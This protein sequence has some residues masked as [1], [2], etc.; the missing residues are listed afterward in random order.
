V[1][2]DVRRQLDRETR[3]PTELK[4]ERS[5]RS[6]PLHRFGCEWLADHLERERAR[7]RGCRPDELVFVMHGRPQKGPWRNV[8]AAPLAYAYTRRKLVALTKDAGLPATGKTHLMRVTFG[9]VAGDESVPAHVLQD[10]LGHA[11]PRTSLIYTRRRS[12]T[13]KRATEAVGRVLGG[14]KAAEK[15]AGGGG[16]AG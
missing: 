4:S 13:V 9:T 6:I 16:V 14:V 15:A 3:Q 10:L 1:T 11:D 5:A 12:A 8:A 2:V 7:G